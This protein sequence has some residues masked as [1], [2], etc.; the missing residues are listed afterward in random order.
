[1]RRILF[2]DLTFC[3]AL[4]IPFLLFC[5]IVNNLLLYM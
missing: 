4:Q 1:L 5:V 2:L 3:L